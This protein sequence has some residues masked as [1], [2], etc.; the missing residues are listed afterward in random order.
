M[1]EHGKRLDAVL[2]KYH[3][4]KKIYKDKCAELSRVNA[5]FVF[6]RRK[7]DEVLLQTQNQEKHQVESCKARIKDLEERVQTL[8][9]EKPLF[10]IC[11]ADNDTLKFTEA[12]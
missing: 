7:C 8:Q 5:E 4:M 10:V 3:H 2:Q 6:L 12:Y 9:K 11:S 1:V